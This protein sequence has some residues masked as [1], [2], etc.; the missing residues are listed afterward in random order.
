MPRWKF[1]MLNTEITPFSTFCP[2]NGSQRTPPLTVTR[3]ETR[4]ASWAYAPGTSC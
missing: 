1:S 4:Q 2:K 3:L